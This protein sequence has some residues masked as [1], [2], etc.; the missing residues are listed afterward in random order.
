MSRSTALTPIRK[1]ADMI[2]AAQ[3][4]FNHLVSR[5]VELG[6]C[7]AFF[8]EASQ[9]LAACSHLASTSG[10]PMLGQLY[11]TASDQMAGKAVA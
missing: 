5:F 6:K 4:V 3:P 8:E 9:H 1:I 7:P 2:P 11:Q 10:K